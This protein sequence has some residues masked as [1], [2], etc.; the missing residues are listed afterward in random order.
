[1]L[2]Y[3]L[4]ILQEA[5]PSERRLGPGAVVIGGG[6]QADLVI[7]ALLDAELCEL[8]L[9]SVESKP[10]KVTAMVEGLVVNGR[11]LKRGQSVSSSR[12]ELSADGV[13]LRL[14]VGGD[15]SLMLAAPGSQ[16]PGSVQ[17]TLTGW[18]DRARSTIEA[19]GTG[20]N[21]GSSGRGARDG[22][23]GGD[24]VGAQEKGPQT[25]PGLA[26]PVVARLRANPGLALMGLALGLALVAF[27]MSGW[28]SARFTPPNLSGL[29]GAERDSPAG[30]LAEIRRRLVAAD[31]A[32]A[33]KA[34]IAGGGI[35]L[36][37]MVDPVQAQRLGELV[38][39]AANR[40]GANLR[41]EV[42][43]A[44]ADAATGIEA[45][46]T[47][48]TKGVVVSGGRLFREG[49]TTPTGWLIEAIGPAEVRLRRDTVS[50]VIAM[51]GPSP[52]LPPTPA[53]AAD[54]VVKAP[55]QSRVRG[56]EFIS[57]APVEPPG[58]SGRQGIGQNGGPVLIQQEEFQ[59]GAPQARPGQA[60]GQVR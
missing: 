30:M 57:S 19:R 25:G 3:N 16:P 5:G 23:A 43:M 59:A 24:D 40:P 8:I 51:S 22:D 4:E 28:P 46:V 38:R 17:D 56:L 37:G 29:A 2:L 50:H 58:Q 20:K 6:L 44:N 41:N 55:S 36:S 52:D 15:E 27:I 13:T 32:S 33:V 9:P 7:P 31:L 39:A 14:G 34:E 18:L 60:R 10:A 49:Q 53:K 12:L 11:E 54:G 42:T 1:V 26:A 48:P 45:V 35:R 47:A 21:P